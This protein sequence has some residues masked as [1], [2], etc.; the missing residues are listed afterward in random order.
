MRL[1]LS[2]P[3]GFAPFNVQ[4]PDNKPFVTFAQQD[5]LKHDDVAGQENG[6]VDELSLSG[7]LRRAAQFTVGDDDRAGQFWQIRRCPRATWATA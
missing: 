5:D 6:F 4:V 2:L 7:G 1:I 3:A